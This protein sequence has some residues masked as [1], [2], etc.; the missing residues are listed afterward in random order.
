M[1]RRLNMFFWIALMFL[2]VGLPATGVAV[3][4]VSVEIG[5]TMWPTVEGE[6]LRAGLTSYRSE[7]QKGLSLQMYSP[8]VTFA[9]MVRGQR[10]EGDRIAS[11]TW[12]SS[13]ESSVR[14]Y[15]QAFPVGSAIKVHYDP[16][17]PVDSRIE[18]GIKFVYVVM[19]FACL[20]FIGLGIWVAVLW[21]RG[22]GTDS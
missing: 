18:V 8:T 19:L 15:L 21:W 6:I 22:A 16:Q 12:S 2:V 9:Y 13:E 14:E 10:Y 11:D 3:W 5:R 20:L 1:R 4:A 7:S 17:N